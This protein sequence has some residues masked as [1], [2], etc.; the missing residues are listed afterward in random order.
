[1]SNNLAT[2]GNDDLAVR[3]THKGIP[4]LVG[5]DPMMTAVRAA[6]DYRDFRARPAILQSAPPVGAKARWVARLHQDG[7]LD[8]A[9][10][11]AL[12]SDYGVPVVPHRIADNAAAAAAAANDLGFPSVLKTAMP[13]IPHKSDV[14]GVQLNL[15]DVVA[16]RGAYGDLASRLGPRVL[17]MPMAGQ[18]VELAFGALAD[19]QFGPLVMVGAGGVL[20]EIMADRCFAL[21]P[22]DGATARRLLDRLRVRPLLDGKRGMPAVDID[23]VAEA[24]ARFSVMA[25]DLAGEFR[26]IDVN[27]VLC[28]ASGCLALDGLIMG[29]PQGAVPAKS[30]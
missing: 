2:V 13:G 15:P 1:M 29:R 22:F 9:E 6:F 18:G 7:A 14:G 23:A 16:V 27:P 21:P 11:L 25:A 3:T 8:E 5:L 12:L 26:E 19:P 30:N 17:V 4:V 10:S 28:T 24:L 20:I